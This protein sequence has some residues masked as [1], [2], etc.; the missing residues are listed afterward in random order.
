VSIEATALS[1]SF[2]ATAAPDPSTFNIGLQYLSTATPTQRQAFSDA[3]LRWQAAITGDLED[4]T[5]NTPAVCG[6]GSPPFSQDIDDVVILVNLIEIDG[7]GNVLASA[8]PC[9]VRD[10]GFLSI[11]GVM[12]FDTADLPALE[13]SGQL[14]SVV[15]HEMAH[16]LGFGLVWTDLGLLADPSLPP[17]L[18]PDP[19]AD[20]HFTGAQAINAFDD[21]GGAGYVAGAKVPVEN[22]GGP[23]TADG[24]W[25]ESVFGSELMTGF[26]NPGQNPLSVVTLAALADQGYAV[27]F[28]TADAYSGLTLSLRAFDTRPKLLLKNDLMRSPIR[29]VDRNGRATGEL[30]R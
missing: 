4:G 22:E 6:E 21:V 17:D 23:G 8:G 24:H 11:L 29:K 26:V 30:R 28:A 13:A 15:V 2:S 18:P 14:S 20:P 16:V 1:V 27:D 10:P 12:Q 7:P 5:L 3:R 25:R 19:G 9:W